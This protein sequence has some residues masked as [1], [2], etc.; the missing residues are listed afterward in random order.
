[1]P[2]LIDIRRRIRAVRSTQQ[3][4]KAMKMI[5]ASRLRKAH[6]R[7]VAARPFSKSMVRVLSSLAGRVDAATHP[8]LA[9][10]NDREPGAH[11]LLLIITADKGLAGGFNANVIRAAAQFIVSRHGQR[12]SLGL[13]G[14]KGRDFFPRRSYPV[15]LERTNHFS[16]PGLQ[17]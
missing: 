3:I 1:M 13:I 8:L 11:I 7:I 4:T 2:S 17:N 10:R 6:D 5:A 16:P 14:R 12:V 9:A 15:R